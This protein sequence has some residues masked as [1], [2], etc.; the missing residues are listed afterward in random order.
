[1]IHKLHQPQVVHRP[2]VRQAGALLPDGEAGPELQAGVRRGGRGGPDYQ[3]RHCPG[4]TDQDQVHTEKLVM[5]V[6]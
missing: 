5:R 2:E 4:P 3:L 1:M 6:G